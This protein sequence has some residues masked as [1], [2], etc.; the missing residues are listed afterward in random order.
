MA[1]KSTT[2]GR[3]RRAHLRYRDPESKVLNFTD[4]HGQNP[5]VALVINES[6][7][8]IACVY[9]GDGDFERGDTILWVESGNIHTPCSVIR[10]TELEED[11]FSLALRIED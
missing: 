11:V 2:D 10:C 9:V 8:G 4:E 3:N 5:F 7:R 6:F 1:K